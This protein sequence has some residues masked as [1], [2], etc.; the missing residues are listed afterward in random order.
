[1]DAGGP[2]RRGRL[3][4]SGQAAVSGQ[5]TRSGQR[6]GSWQPMECGRPMTCTQ[7]LGTPW[8]R[9]RLINVI[10]VAIG[11]RAGHRMRT[12]GAGSLDRGRPWYRGTP[13]GCG[14]P[15]ASGQPSGCGQLMGCGHPT[16]RPA[17]RTSNQPTGRPSDRPPDR[18]L[19]RPSDRPPGGP[20]DS[21]AGRPIVR[22]A[23]GSTAE[24]PTGRLIRSHRSAGRWIDRPPDRRS[25]HP[26]SSKQ[27]GVETPRPRGR[28]DPPRDRG[29]AG[30]RGGGAGRRPRPRGA[31][32]RGH[33][34]EPRA[35]L[36]RRA[37]AQSRAE[38]LGAEGRGCVGE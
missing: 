9:P 35:G 23:D 16:D 24:R 34:R 20:S 32:A 38:R 19:D 5:P 30:V 2:R 22:L 25:D 26:G 18:P 28:H 11:M 1:M 21:P 7:E 17:D 4:G 27:T 8:D 10:R 6:M 31:V 36:P 37:R 33:G 13:L 15:M 12:V 14:Q 29:G 3:M